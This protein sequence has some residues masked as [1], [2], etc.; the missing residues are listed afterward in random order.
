MESKILKR[1]RT[2]CKKCGKRTTLYHGRYESGRKFISC[3]H[4]L[5]KAP[6]DKKKD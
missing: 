5:A 3:T 4:C 1:K 6:Y 2:R